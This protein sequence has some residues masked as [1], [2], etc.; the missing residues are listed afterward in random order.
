MRDLKMWRYER[1]PTAHHLAAPS[2]NSPTHPR[3]SPEACPQYLHQTTPP[4]SATAAP[5]GT[6]PQVRFHC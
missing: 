1:D 2:G 4:Q 5:P 3:C 6:D